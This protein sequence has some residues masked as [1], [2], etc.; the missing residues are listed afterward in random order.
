MTPAAE[1]LLDKQR[2]RAE[3]AKRKLAERDPNAGVTPV[4]DE[5]SD[6]VAGGGLLSDN[7]LDALL[8]KARSQSA[9]A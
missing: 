6:I 2:I 4:L 8:A 5:E 7:E 9:K 3:L 1:R